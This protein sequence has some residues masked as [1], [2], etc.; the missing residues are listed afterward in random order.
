MAL[1]RDAL[2]KKIDKA[3]AHLQDSIVKRCPFYSLIGVLLNSLIKFTQSKRVPLQIV[4]HMQTRAAQYPWTKEAAFVTEFREQFD[5]F[6]QTS[7]Q[8]SEEA[9]DVVQLEV[10]LEEEFVKLQFTTPIDKAALREKWSLLP[11]TA[12]EDLLTRYINP[13]E[14]TSKVTVEKHV[15]RR[16]VMFAILSALQYSAPLA[17]SQQHPPPRSAPP[18][19]KREREEPVRDPDEKSSNV[20]RLAALP[21]NKQQYD[22]FSV[23][24]IG[25]AGSDREDD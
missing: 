23:S 7:P 2:L 19:P 10:Q 12:K 8:A 21:Q 6:Y 5:Q 9:K 11:R 22:H 24:P 4:R 14:N 16:R 15:T 18:R 17:A 20:Q 1:T 3:T 13:Y 25:H